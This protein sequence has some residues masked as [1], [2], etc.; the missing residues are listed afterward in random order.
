MRPAYICL[1]IIIIALYCLIFAHI[2]I[3][4]INVPL[5]DLITGNI[6]TNNIEFQIILNTTKIRPGQPIEVTLLIYNN[7]STIAKA[8]ESNLKIFYPLQN[9]SNLPFSLALF[10]GYYSAYNISY[11]TP[12]KIFNSTSGIKPITLEILPHSDIVKISNH[13]LKAKINIIIKG[14]WN[15]TFTELKPGIYTLAATD[16]FGKILIRHFQVI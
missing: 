6:K 9:Q 12:L 4:G 5:I 13:E 14:Y 1:A 7:G 3:Y 16:I 2:L 8:Q 10:K 11:A 15:K